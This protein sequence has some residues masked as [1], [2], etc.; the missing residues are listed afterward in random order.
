[1][2]FLKSK[3]FK[4]IVAWAITVIALYY[5]FHSVDWNELLAHLKTADKTY[6][7][8]AILL[9]CSSYLFRARRWQFLFPEKP[10]ISYIDSA[11]VLILGFFMN[12]ILPARAGEIVR[13]HMGSK[14][15]GLTRTLVLATVA[16]E[17]LLDGLALSL[18]FVVFSV[19]IGGEQIS[20]E[21]LY[22]AYFFA[23]AAAGVGVLIYFRESIFLIIEKL[24]N[25]LGHKAADF[26]LKRIKVFIDGLTPMFDKSRFG[27]VVLWSIF[28]WSIE[29]S[30][31]TFVALAFGVELSIA[32]YVLFLVVV[33]FSSLI[34]A[35]PG[36][37]GVIEAVTKTVLVS[38]GLDAELALALVITQHLIQYLV[39]CIPGAIIM[40]T[41]RDRIRAVEGSGEP[42]AQG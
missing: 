39:V 20:H 9:T 29:L 41:W 10:S 2:V 8:L 11:R 15:T 30:V 17:R 14:A 42:V 12:N 6:I 19:G 5:A 7:I 27:I 33:N 3:F 40:F 31:Y 37:I 21:L 13:A 26:T 36:G 25:R 32:F 23:V 18:F 38:V 24:N 22:V 16:S 4:I 34:P 1:M 35:A 28:I